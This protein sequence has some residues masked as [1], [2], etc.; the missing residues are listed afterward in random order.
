MCGSPDVWSSTRN[1]AGCRSDSSLT[2]DRQTSRIREITAEASFGGEPP[3]SPPS[4]RGAES[5]VTC[6]DCVCARTSL[7]NR[8]SHV[9]TI[10]LCP[11]KVRRF[12]CPFA[13]P[14]LFGETRNHSAAADR[15]QRHF[16]RA[17]VEPPKVLLRFLRDPPRACDRL[18][19]VI[20]MDQ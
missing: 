9:I 8:G 10:A 13:G 11:R 17:Q 14:A 6:A 20:G 12:I 18:G 1:F 3:H 16:E 4:S 15:D 5:N 2:P 19:R 7:T